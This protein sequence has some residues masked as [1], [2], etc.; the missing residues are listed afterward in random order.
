M[1]LKVRILT[2]FIV[3]TV[4]VTGTGILLPFFLPDMIVVSILLALVCSIIIV[5]TMRW[6]ENHALSLNRI[7]RESRQAKYVTE[8][9]KLGIKFPLSWSNFSISPDAACILIQELMFIKPKIVVEC[10]SGDST[11]LIAHCLK[12]MG[13]GKVYSLEHHKKWADHTRDMINALKLKEYCKVIDAPLEKIEIDGQA[14]DWYSGYDLEIGK[15][16]IDFLFIDGPSSQKEGDEAP[17]YPAIPVFYSQFKKGARIILDDAKR[18]GEE[19]YVEQWK[20][21]YGLEGEINV[22][23]DRGL[24]LL[25]FNNGDNL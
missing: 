5:I 24:A 15:E 16:T 6:K 12:E 21:N 4:L 22:N 13:S 10:G 11:I 3:I 19:R 17:R 9:S 1:S 23:T 18:F 25:I 20:K 14:W 8:I 7:Y 2:V